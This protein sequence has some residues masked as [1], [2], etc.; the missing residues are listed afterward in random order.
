MKKLICCDLEGVLGNKPSCFMELNIAFGADDR[1]YYEQYLRGELDYES[2]VR[3]LGTMW[4]SSSS[5]KPTRQ[6]FND[7]FKG[8]YQRMNGVEEFVSGLRSKGYVVT[9]V[10]NS[11]N[12][13]CEMAKEDLGLDDYSEAQDLIFDDNDNLKE[14]KSSP[15]FFHKKADALRMFM[16]KYG[17]SRENTAAIGDSDADAEMLKAAGRGI[18]FNPSPFLTR[19]GAC[20]KEL[21][22]CGVI[23]VKERDLTRVLPY[24]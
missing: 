12:Q 5:P 22:A 20:E 1:K 23:I 2:W 13:L 16:E 14:L 6:Y 18:L 4:K 8:Y 24:L 21:K 11:F 3:E 15:Y 10:S 7:F 17:V 9:I 19:F